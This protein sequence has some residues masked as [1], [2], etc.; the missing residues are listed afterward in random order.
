MRNQLKRQVPVLVML[1]TVAT[2]SF[3]GIVDA[4]QPLPF[5]DGSLVALGAACAVGLVWLV[6]SKKK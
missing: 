4:F 6:R 5:G 1:S 3:A 2:Q